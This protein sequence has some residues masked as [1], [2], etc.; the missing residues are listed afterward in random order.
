MQLIDESQA[1]IMDRE[2][3]S[4]LARASKGMSPL[5]LSLATLDWVSHLAISPG[6][7]TLLVQSFVQKLGKLGLY[8]L[9][10][11]IK[12][13]AQRPSS[14]VER[15]MSSE[16]WQRW[17]FNVLAEAHQSSKDWLKEATLGV[18]GVRK[19]HEILVHAAADQ[20]L[21]LLSPELPAHE[22][23]SPQSYLERERPQSASR[24]YTFC[25]RSDG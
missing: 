8:S 6:K 10:S 12:K 16:D 5:E 17:P 21:D 23:R 15:R 7:R 13:D 11:M 18:E 14:G 2:F 25:Q 1:E 19:E 24:C 20:V 3:R 22:P 4:M 9:K